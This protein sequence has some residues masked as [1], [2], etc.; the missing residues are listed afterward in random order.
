LP[1]KGGYKKNAPLKI[2]NKTI[3]GL[4]IKRTIQDFFANAKI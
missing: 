1:I 4:A 3:F 2:T